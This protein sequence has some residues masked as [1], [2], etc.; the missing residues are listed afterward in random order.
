MAGLGPHGRIGVRI[1]PIRR[2]HTA[3]N[4]QLMLKKHIFKSS[5]GEG[6]H[7]IVSTMACEVE[8]VL[9]PMESATTEKEPLENC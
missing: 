7:F 8:H 1:R 9:L 6:L 2:N 3:P 4:I 5:L